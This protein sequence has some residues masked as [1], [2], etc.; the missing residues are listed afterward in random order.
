MDDTNGNINGNI[1]ELQKKIINGIINEL[2][3]R[4]N[5]E[6]KLFHAN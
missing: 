2:T 4:N 6:C 3:M 5:Y 1:K